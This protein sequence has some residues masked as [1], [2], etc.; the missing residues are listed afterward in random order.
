MKLDVTTFNVG[1]GDAILLD[2]HGNDGERWTCLVDGGRSK[3]RICGH[4]ARVGIRHL[5]LVVGT[6]P[7]S[8]HISGLMGIHAVVS[9]VD[10][11][12]GPP[13][14]AYERHIWMFKQRGQAAIRRCRTVEAAMQSL[15]AKI[16]YP[17]EDFTS[18]PFGNRG[19]I[20]RVL[21]PAA[22]LIRTLLISDDVRWLCAQPITPLGW[23]LQGAESEVEKHPEIEAL[24]R[25]LA[26]GALEP[27]DLQG[28]F[29]QRPSSSDSHT[30]EFF[31]DSLLNNTSIVIWLEVPSNSRRYRILLTGDQENWTYLLARNS[32]GLN[33]DIF[34]APHH[35]GRLYLEQDPAHEEVLSH[36]RPRVVLFSASGLHD[37]PRSDTREA[38]MRWGAT[39]FC[40]SQRSTE[41]VLGQPSGTVCC[42]TNLDCDSRPGSAVCLTLDDQGIRSKDRACHSGIGS[43]PGPV[44]Q[45][46]QHI[47]D[48]SGIMNHLAENELRKHIEW[49]KVKLHELHEEHVSRIV[50]NKPGTTPVSQND[51]KRLAAAEG[52]HSLEYNL[53]TVLSKGYERQAFWARREGQGERETWSAY[54]IPNDD[55]IQNFFRMLHAKAGI[56]FPN[57]YD[58]VHR[59]P[60]S[61]LLRLVPDGLMLFG[62]MYLHYPPA[63]LV[64]VVWPKLIA[65]FKAN[66]HC[67]ISGKSVLLSPLATQRELINAVIKS[68]TIWDLPDSD[69]QWPFE[70]R[71]GLTGQPSQQNILLGGRHKGGDSRGLDYDNH[72]REISEL[73]KST[74]FTHYGFVHEFWSVDLYHHFSRGT[75]KEVAASVFFENRS[76]LLD[77][78]SQ[79]ALTLDRLW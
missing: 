11:Y 45:I 43:A 47:I 77:K 48:P 76:E 34:K 3:G 30:A 17:L 65:D 22:S 68:L 29:I 7:D 4:L 74:L 64:D 9:R 73:L 66:W 61:V 72:A 2:W 54:K 21:S 32:R 59:G 55:D 23:L 69:E 46:R 10:E 51:L 53:S 33:A 58:Q 15:G 26:T 16:R 75:S 5:N 70:M 14:P 40:T 19:P 52:R 44:I 1:H 25:A 63:T 24:D 56:L 28:R 41:F 37:L 35:G 27:R 79:S 39:V 13:V 67:Y 6:H 38:A 20:L 42:H 49:T 12:W 60:S 78:W 31:G 8:D 18:A 57:D 62:D 36:V 50:P 71:V